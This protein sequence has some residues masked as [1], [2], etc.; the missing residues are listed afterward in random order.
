MSS[1][2]YNTD[3]IYKPSRTQWL[4][5]CIMSVVLWCVVV[6]VVLFCFAGIVCYIVTSHHVMS[7]GVVQKMIRGFS[8][9]LLHSLHSPTLSLY[10]I[11]HHFIQSLLS[12]SHLF[13]S[14]LFSSDQAS[15]LLFSNLHNSS[16]TVHPSYSFFSF[17]LP[18]SHA[19][20]IHYS[21][22]SS[23]GS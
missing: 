13:T 15:L 11:P 2:A 6:L 21:D 8:R 20:P 16:R 23:A 17:L 9:S 4:F 19:Q 5:S 14:R 7:C 22:M 3:H 1:C 12:S 18:T 10:K